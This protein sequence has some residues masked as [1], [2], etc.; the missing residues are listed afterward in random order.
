[1]ADHWPRKWQREEVVKGA[2]LGEIGVNVGTHEGKCGVADYGK[3][4]GGRM[5]GE[6]EEQMKSFD[7]NMVM[8]TATEERNVATEACFFLN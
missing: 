2:F 6:V 3:I 4:C 1:M 5:G 8:K 7:N